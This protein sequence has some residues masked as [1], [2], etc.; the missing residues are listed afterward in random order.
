MRDEPTRLTRSSH[1]HCAAPTTSAARSIAW[2]NPQ[3]LGQYA[4]ERRHRNAHNLYA[5][6]WRRR[7]IAD[8]QTAGASK[9]SYR[10]NELFGTDVVD[11]Q[12]AAIGSVHDIVLSPQGGKIACLVI[13]HSNPER[14]RV[15]CARRSRRKPA[16]LL[17]YIANFAGSSRSYSFL[18]T[19]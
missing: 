1:H 11:A 10:P 7:Q 3:T 2:H 18:T 15:R 12:G 14:P 9:V 4:S 19:A 8:V 6:G 5:D 17:R 13:R 16:D